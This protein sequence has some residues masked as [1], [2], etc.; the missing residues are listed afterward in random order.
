[1][2]AFTNDSVLG[3]ETGAKTDDSGKDLEVSDENRDP[4][5]T[6][7][8]S[9]VKKATLN[10]STPSTPKSAARKEDRST[11]LHRRFL[12]E[13]DMS[14]AT[15]PRS[16][17]RTREGS[18]GKGR[19]SPS[20]GKESPT[21]QKLEV[22]QNGFYF[23]CEL[24]ISKIT[25]KK[26][27]TPAKGGERVRTPSPCKTPSK[28]VVDPLVRNTGTPTKTT[29]R[30][31]HGP[32]KPKTNDN[33]KKSTLAK[34]TFSTPLRKVATPDPTT[35]AMTDG[36]L[37]PKMGGFH[38]R[39]HTPRMSTPANGLSGTPLRDAA[40]LDVGKAMGAG[41][42]LPT[43]SAEMP[44]RYE[45]DDFLT[46][47]PILNVPSESV[48][49]SMKEEA[50]LSEDVP[51][52]SDTSTFQLDA[53]AKDAQRT[54]PSRESSFDIGDMMAGLK[55]LVSKPR[56]EGEKS[57]PPTPLR[58]A[59]ERMNSAALR[60]EG[61]GAEGFEKVASPM[62]SEPVSSVDAGQQLSVAL[63]VRIEE[64]RRHDLPQQSPS[65]QSA[66]NTVVT[67]PL[68]IEENILQYP[69]LLFPPPVAA[70][71]TDLVPKPGNSP[72]GPKKPVDRQDT[73]PVSSQSKPAI[74]QTPRRAGTDPMVFL[75]MRRDMTTMEASMRHSF[76]F[77]YS[78]S[79]RQNTFEIPAMA[80]SL[81]DSV[82]R[83]PAASKSRRT[84]SRTTSVTSTVSTASSMNVVRASMLLDV[85]DQNAMPAA[86]CRL[87]WPYAGK[88]PAQ[89]RQE[90]L[91]AVKKKDMNVWEVE[92]AK[93]EQAGNN[94]DQ[95]TKSSQMKAKA[96]S[97]R[98]IKDASRP[99]SP[100][101]SRQTPTPARTKP[102]ATPAFPKRIP[103]GGS[104]PRGPRTSIFDAPSSATKP[105]PSICKTTTAR[106]RSSKPPFDPCTDARPREK[107]FA[108]ASEIAD[109]VAEWHSED[110][111]RAAVEVE[112]ERMK[113]WE[114]EKGTP[115]KSLE[116]KD[117]EG[118]SY[119]PKGSP[120]KIGAA[121]PEKDG[122]S[123]LS[124]K[125]V[126]EKGCTPIRTASKK[127]MGTPTS[128]KSKP[129]PSIFTSTP[130]SKPANPVLARVRH[131][132]PRTPAQRTPKQPDPNASRTPSKEIESSLDRAI[133]A[134]IEEDISSGREYTPGGNRV[135]D[136]VGAR[137][138]D[139]LKQRRR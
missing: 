48:N 75:A 77:E 96:M 83:D 28:Q 37:P 117:V 110:R 93:L 81:L 42:E 15:P 6:P 50:A 82:S 67:L 17:S 13:V 7:Q 134:K 47:T 5:V 36:T 86:G 111:K 69:P 33:L 53:N 35:R 89:E 46:P 74:R 11:P 21:K 57:A 22:G 3:T 133:D 44:S 62:T 114:D 32:P 88:T 135:L 66:S 131:Q 59:A 84:L 71:V 40:G 12:K 49:T 137:K 115:S 51:A 127:A 99:E 113:M 54:K 26:S 55:G 124:K 102:T 2:C 103:V 85:R 56:K 30:D 136:L 91:D 123:R 63:P 138:Q 118:E 27:G 29:H 80:S 120:M 72:T 38:L 41:T 39:T 139:E 125:V 122:Q 60:K 20:K 24:S 132:A 43:K 31:L 79:G 87:K 9:P 68:T 4:V 105:S 116:V 92:A 100:A 94:S 98:Q 90:R 34:P 45:K 52:T 104:I 64:R 16:L 112:K 8:S 19:G 126:E 73:T 18:P 121:S 65:P 107:K 10:R 58:R 97:R 14:P 70:P 25:P 76:G 95:R 106:I 130:E 109:R 128:K 1:M 61:D 101:P 23:S 108:G 78:F 119:T 129:K